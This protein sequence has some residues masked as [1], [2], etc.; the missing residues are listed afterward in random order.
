MMRKLLFTAAAI[1]MLAGCGP[2]VSVQPLYTDDDAVYE[3]GL[4]GAWEPVE[5]G[6]VW[7]IDGDGKSPYRVVT[8]S[9]NARDVERYEMRLVRLGEALF[10]DLQQTGK[11]DEGL[12]V[13]SHIIARLRL[14]GDRLSV[15]LL[16]SE[17]LDQRVGEWK[18]PN[19]KDRDE[20]ILTGSTEQLRA[21]VGRVGG[22]SRAFGDE[23]SA[24]RLR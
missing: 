6:G 3:A 7:F 22:E 19:R 15:A 1:T 21:F 13:R 10:A 11:P 20:V 2:L 16:G 8:V 14:E 17:W 23:A 9:G 4:T 12:S 5:D 24:Q 18:F